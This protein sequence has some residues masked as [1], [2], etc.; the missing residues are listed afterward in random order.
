MHFL[1]TNMSAASWLRRSPWWPTA[2]ATLDK[3][4]HTSPQPFCKCRCFRWGHILTRTPTFATN[5][6]LVQQQLSKSQKASERSCLL[7]LGT[8]CAFKHSV[9]DGAISSMAVSR[10]L[11]FRPSAVSVGLSSLFIKMQTAHSSSFWHLLCTVTTSPPSSSLIQYGQLW[12]LSS[13]DGRLTGS[14]EH[15]QSLLRALHTS[16]TL[17]K[18]FWQR[19]AWYSWRAAFCRASAMVSVSPALA[20][21]TWLRRIT[22]ES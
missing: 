9:I 17:C 21:S 11:R 8:S 19:S 10:S 14:A 7:S 6:S 3:L 18:T 12:S 20:F 1:R 16:R 5:R 15:V 2:L 13:W 22:G 4:D